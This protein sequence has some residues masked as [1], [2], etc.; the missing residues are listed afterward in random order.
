MAQVAPHDI[1]VVAIGRNEG[2]RLIGCLTS[3]QSAT[4]NIVYVDSGSTDGS[5]TAAEKIGA[6]VVKLDLSQP[7]TA[8]RARNEGFAT[9]KALR[10]DIRFV[11]FVDGDCTLAQLWIEKALAFMEQR[12]DVAI[13]CGRRRER[14][15]EASIY[16]RL[17]DD[18]WNTPVGEATACGGDA[19]V[20]VQAFTRIGGFRPSLIAGEE[21]ELCLRLRENGW[22]IWRLN[23]EMTQHDAAMY[24]FTQW[25][26]RSVR[27]GYGLAEVSRLHWSS[28]RPIWRREVARAV[29]WAGIFPL[30]VGA[31]ALIHPFV[32]WATLAYPLQL[33][34]VGIRRGAASSE[35][36]WYAILSVPAK[37]AELQG[38]LKFYWRNWRQQTT[39]LIEYKKS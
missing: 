25:W 4:A 35:N 33:F 13:V 12:A 29:F 26:I 2:Q 7:F 6:C 39:Q 1:G 16:N 17:L 8:A 24:T 36:W 10:P 38:I 15:P 19:L 37:F 28:A 11:Q 21:P 5:V 32:L 3:V 14:Y 31:G 30:V 22:K 34:R 20:Q 27:S 9:L 23:E 18:E